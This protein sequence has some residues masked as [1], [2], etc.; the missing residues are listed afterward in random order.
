MREVGGKREQI[1]I[2]IA[3]TEAILDKTVDKNK[4]LNQNQIKIL[5]C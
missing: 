4:T 1:V 2:A 3:D 5:S